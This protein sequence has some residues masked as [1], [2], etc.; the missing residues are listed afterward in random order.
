[1]TKFETT[2]A[3]AVVKVEA[4]ILHWGMLASLLRERIMRCDEMLRPLPTFAPIVSHNQIAAERAELVNRL[5]ALR[6]ER[7]AAA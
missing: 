3:T 1:M 4:G 5:V 7:M 2:Y 6:N